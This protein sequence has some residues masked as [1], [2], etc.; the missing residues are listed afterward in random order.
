MSILEIDREENEDL[1]E[2]LDRCEGDESIYFQ[3]NF[4]DPFAH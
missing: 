1:A 2:Q 4:K 3:D